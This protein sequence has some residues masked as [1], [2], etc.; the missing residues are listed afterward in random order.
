GRGSP[1][2][3][4]AETQASA[5]PTPSAEKPQ[6]L[7]FFNDQG[8]A[9]AR[10]DL[11]DLAHKP[12]QGTTLAHDVGVDD[13]SPTPGTDD[14]A[15]LPGEAAPAPSAAAPAAAPSAAPVAAESHAPA[16]APKA[17]A[18]DLFIQVFSSK[19]EAQAKKLARK[20]RDAKLPAFLSPAG[21]K[22]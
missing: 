4:A 21:G 22:Y 8:K 6:E 11:Q 20:L 18:G 5:Q 17:A 3:A 7:A 2:A 9:T 10:P 19:D 13:A 16:A 14:E 12:K 1:A 15:G